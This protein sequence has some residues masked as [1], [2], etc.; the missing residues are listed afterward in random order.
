MSINFYKYVFCVI[1]MAIYGR[2]WSG[3]IKNSICIT[4]KRNCSKAE[5]REEKGKNNSV[6]LT[7]LRYLLVNNGLD[8]VC[9]H[10]SDC[11]ISVKET[12]F[13]FSIFCKFDQ[14]LGMCGFL[15][16]NR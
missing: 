2:G 1:V 11:V 7:T 15:L 10:S 16:K 6:K 4:R 9:C 5:A 13:A 12:I 14:A 8:L 3:L